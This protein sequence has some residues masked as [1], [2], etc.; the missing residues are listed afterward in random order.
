MKTPPEVQAVLGGCSRGAP[1]SR[2]RTLWAQVPGQTWQCPG[3]HGAQGIGCGLWTTAS[4]A[5]ENL[6]FAHNHA[7]A[8]E[9]R[10][11]VAEMEAALEPVAE[12]ADR[13]DP[14]EGDDDRRCWV[15]EF[16][17]TLG[18]LRRA[19]AALTPPASQEGQ[20]DAD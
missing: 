2:A 8:Q 19:R 9:L 7:L 17:P 10:A 16:T 18:N 6:S 4:H 5:H 13:Y 12:L 20:A 15:D 3:H 1:W 11:R 14:E